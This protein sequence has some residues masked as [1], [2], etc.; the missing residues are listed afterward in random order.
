MESEKWHV[1]ERS[2]DAPEIETMCVVLHVDRWYE[3]TWWQKSVSPQRCGRKIQPETSGDQTLSHS[4]WFLCKQASLL[5]FW[6]TATAEKLNLQTTVIILV[7]WY[8]NLSVNKS[9]LGDLRYI[10]TY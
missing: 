1:A 3:T 8:W 10:F 4:Y 2:Y 7:E 9:R 6:P 5:E